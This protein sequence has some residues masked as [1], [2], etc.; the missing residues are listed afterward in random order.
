MRLIVTLIT[1]NRLDYT[2]RTLRSLWDSI[3]DDADYFLVVVDNNSTDGTRQYLTDLQRRGR[4]NIL[5]LNEDNYYP[6]KA[7]NIG[8]ERGLQVYHATHLM[9]LDNDMQLERGWDSKVE[10][11]FRAIP[12][13]GQLGIDHEAIEHPDAALHKRVINGYAINEWPGC[14]G[15]PCVVKRKV[16]DSGVRWP[17]MRWDDDR[18]NAIQEDSTFSKLIRDRGYL[19]GHTQLELGRTFANKENWLDYPE[20]YLKTMDER[21]YKDNVK[22]LEGLK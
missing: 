19:V 18:H 15:G 13:L 22:Y 6:G 21:G 17:E 9:R 16:W 11:Y 3:S 14:V 1:Y 4:I 20:Y 10:G 5:V 8:W 12:E 7:C 2:K